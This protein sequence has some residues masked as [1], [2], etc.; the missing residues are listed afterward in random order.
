MKRLF[1]LILAVGFWLTGAAHA[2]VIS[3]QKFEDLLYIDHFDGDRVRALCN[4]QADIGIYFSATGDEEVRPEYFDFLQIS[5]SELK[6]FNGGQ[7]VRAAEGL[8]NA[9]FDIC[10]DLPRPRPSDAADGAP[11]LFSIIETINISDFEFE[12]YFSDN[13]LPGARPIHET[14]LKI[15]AFDARYGS[16]TLY[17]DAGEAWRF[18][19]AELKMTVKNLPFYDAVQ[20]PWR[21]RSE[22]PRIQR[23]DGSFPCYYIH[24]SLTAVYRHP[25]TDCNPET[26]EGEA[27][28]G[29]MSLKQA[30]QI[31]ARL[32]LEETV[33]VAGPPSRIG[34]S[35]EVCCSDLA[36]ITGPEYRFE[37]FASCA[38]RDRTE[39]VDDAM[40]YPA[41]DNEVMTPAPRRPGA[42]P[43][44]TEP[45][46]PDPNEG[47]GRTELSEC[48]EMCD[49]AG[50]CE[51]ERL[52]PGQCERIASNRV[53][54]DQLCPTP[55]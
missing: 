16:K 24:R 25:W 9:V 14:I 36:G 40:C 49:F 26:L 5:A 46:L 44:G 23:V 4:P 21:R 6:D 41:G 37:S 1:S 34:A 54:D 55:R 52:F 27:P 12:Y 3:Q 32:F 53:V 45:P 33:N 43:A 8:R 7:F 50:Y 10:N 42:D 38:A 20:G 2:D 17:D 51:Y 48:C 19:T 31:A 28:E 13:R 11:M 47:S 39:I 15:V 30:T 29:G 22:D 35:A 18:E